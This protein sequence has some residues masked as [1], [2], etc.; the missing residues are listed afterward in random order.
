[1]LEPRHVVDVLVA[2]ER[3]CTGGRRAAGPDA[4][5][6]SPPATTRSSGLRSVRV[7]SAAAPAAAVDIESNG[8]ERQLIMVMM[9]ELGNRMW[10]HLDEFKPSSLAKC[11]W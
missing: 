3:I 6:P 11:I 2:M 1:M 4:P 5:P 8:T 10:G 7:Q 9:G